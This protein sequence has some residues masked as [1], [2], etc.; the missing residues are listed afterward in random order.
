[1]NL[2]SVKNLQAFGTSLFP[3][4]FGWLLLIQQHSL[5]ENEGALVNILT[6]FFLKRFLLPKS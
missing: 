4:T 3:N 2:F 6:F 1:M 5:F